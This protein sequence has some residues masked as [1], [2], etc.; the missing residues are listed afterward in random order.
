MAILFMLHAMDEKKGY[1]TFLYRA[2]LVILGALLLIILGGTIFGLS[3]RGKG[4][5][6][7]VEQTGAT[8]S[9]G[10]EQIFTGVGRLRLTTAG[11]PP[12]TVILSVAF[13]YNAADRPFAEE[14]ASKVGALRE[15]SAGYFGAISAEE[16]R[17]KK[18]EDLKAALL[19]EYNSL[20]RLGQIEKLY[21]TDLVIIE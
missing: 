15:K 11:A 17:M 20:L 18:D 4:E 5:R 9:P 12:A 8:E 13:P 7:N 1:L 19:S 3:S 14:L 2:L 16:L 10:E 6:T 21:F